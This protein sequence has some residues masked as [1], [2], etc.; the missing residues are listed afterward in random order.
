MSVSA[1]RRSASGTPGRGTAFPFR[2]F[3][4]L[5]IAVHVHEKAQWN[6]CLRT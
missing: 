2:D 5:G 6:V 4:T 1:Q 3:G